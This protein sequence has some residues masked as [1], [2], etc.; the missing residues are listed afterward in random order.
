MSL[1][2]FTYK[3]NIKMGVKAMTFPDVNWIYMVLDVAQR[4]DRVNMLMGIRLLYKEGNITVGEIRG[5][6]SIVT[7]MRHRVDW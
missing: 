1:A 7:G 2:N 5:S 4:I 6:H 3:D